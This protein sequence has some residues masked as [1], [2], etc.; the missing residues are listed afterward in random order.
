VETGLNIFENCIASQETTVKLCASA[1]G[2]L[3]IQVIAG[4]IRTWFEAIFIRL[5][6]ESVFSFDAFLYAYLSHARRDKM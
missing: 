5:K 2:R 1:N 3:I 4:Q 6:G